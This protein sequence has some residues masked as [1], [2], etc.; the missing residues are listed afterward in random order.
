MEKSEDCVKSAFGIGLERP[1]TSGSRNGMWYSKYKLFKLHGADPGSIC[2]ANKSKWRDCKSRLQFQYLH[3]SSLTQQLKNH[4]N[5]VGIHSSLPQSKQPK[6]HFPN[7]FSSE[8]K[9]MKLGS[10]LSVRILF[11]QCSVLDGEYKKTD[12]F[13]KIWSFS[14][15]LSAWGGSRG[16]TETSICALKVNT[17]QSYSSRTMSRVTLMFHLNL[18]WKMKKLLPFIPETSCLD[19]HYYSFEYLLRKDNINKAATE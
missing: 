11:I 12:I 9:W 3:A 5:P 19:L 16:A 18:R 2:H 7:T 1:L 14:S 6:C 15:I 17:L 8:W 10:T 4:Q 13:R